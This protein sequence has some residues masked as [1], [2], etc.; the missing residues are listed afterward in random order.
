MPTA[1]R[2]NRPGTRG[3]TAPR[4]RMTTDQFLRYLSEHPATAA[5][6]R[7]LAQALDP[8]GAH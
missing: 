1:T 8:A 5:L 7:D 6:G 3:A 2:P 4:R